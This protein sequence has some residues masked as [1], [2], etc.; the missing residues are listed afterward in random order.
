VH[1]DPAPAMGWFQGIKLAGTNM[2]GIF[3]AG[4]FYQDHGIV[5]W[6]VHHPERTIVVELEHEHL[7]KLVVE[8]LDPEQTVRQIAAMIT[9][10]RG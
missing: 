2:P 1:A 10:P 9:A 7:K 4:M 5:F 6:D 8:V 3:R